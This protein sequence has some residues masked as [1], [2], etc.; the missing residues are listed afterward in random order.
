MI[1]TKTDMDNW[2]ESTI[3][4]LWN[5]D[6]HEKYVFK[7][8]RT[9]EIPHPEQASTLGLFMGGWQMDQHTS[10]IEIRNAWASGVVMYVQ[11]YSKESKA[12]VGD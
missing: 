7:L 3:D 1:E 11:M 6:G 5:T 4:D 12:A 8:D 2:E 9:H 10:Q